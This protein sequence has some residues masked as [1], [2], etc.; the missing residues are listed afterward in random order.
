MLKNSKNIITARLRRDG[1]VPVY[2]LIAA[3]CV[4]LLLGASTVLAQESPV[5]E[6]DGAVVI[7]LDDAIQM[8][9]GNN[10]KAKIADGGLKVA[11]GG[12]QQALG[13][14]G[15]EITYSH[16][17]A[18]SESYRTNSGV[19]EWFSNNT[20][21]SLPIYTG[22]ARRGNLRAASNNY[23]K[24]KLE[25]GRADQE[26]KLDATTAYYNVLQ[27]RN[28]VT[29]SSES[30]ERLQEHLK[31]AQSRF[32][33]GVVAKV[34]VLRSQVELANAEQE[35]IKAQNSYDIAVASLNNVIGL[36]LDTRTLLKDELTH[37]EY[38]KTLPD[39]LDFALE[40]QP[41]ISQAANDIGAARGN[42]MSARSGYLPN[43][44]ISA[45]YSWGKND[46]PGSDRDNW[47]VAAT[48][49]LTLFDS[50]ITRGRVNAAQGALAQREAGYQQVLDQVLL[51]VRSNY[52]SLREAEKRI[53]TASVVVETAEEDYKIALV[54][55]QAGVGTNT[56]VLD[57]QVSLSQAKTNY[58][59]AL[60]DYNT[61]WAY[62]ENAM[63]VPV[64]PQAPITRPASVHSYMSA[65]RRSQPI[66]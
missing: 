51:S 19:N 37:M 32:D 52:F 29:L 50:N 6:A 23:E 35:F 17:D 46:F 64:V 38:S 42:V 55:Y 1:V 5:A 26:I 59:Q 12:M 47:S 11:A 45:G 53:A 41:Q 34:D 63:G 10:H 28:M 3:V 65:D 8:A 2:C 7:N 49:N 39:C 61:S 21:V 31:N 16:R 57:A 66:N 18:R 48:L 4:C 36:P 24:A 30:V 56:D 58:V 62:L 25:V 43:V 27:T 20:G 60:Y 9:L 14:Y 54:R 44:S 40:H 22:G 15:P 33:A 13:R